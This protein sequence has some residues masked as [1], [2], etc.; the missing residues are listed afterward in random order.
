MTTQEFLDKYDN[1]EIFTE[2]ELYRIWI[3]DTEIEME[4]IEEGTGEFYRWNHEEWQIVKIGDRCFDIARMAGNT[5]Y[6]ENEYD[7]QPQEVY[8]IQKV[9]TVWEAVK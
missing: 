3:G 1:K 7:I 5:E 2:D 8:P 9:I 4:V 6:Q